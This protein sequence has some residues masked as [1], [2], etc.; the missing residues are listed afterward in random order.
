MHKKLTDG[1]IPGN[2]AKRGVKSPGCVVASFRG[3]A[4]PLVWLLLIG[5]TVFGANVGFA[6]KGIGTRHSV[7][8]TLVT[9]RSTISKNTSPHR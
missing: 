8:V 9:H 2:H 6:V 5:P 7:L 1:Y 4:G 3:R